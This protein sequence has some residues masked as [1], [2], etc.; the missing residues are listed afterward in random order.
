LG[1]GHDSQWQ[2]HLDE[3]GQS[4]SCA[5]DQLLAG[6]W[7]DMLSHYSKAEFT[8]LSDRLIAISSLVNKIAGLTGGH[9]DSGCWL[10]TIDRC[11][12]WWVESDA[13]SG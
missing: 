6:A 13:S 3:A 5:K 9:Y 12:A 10:E 4:S 2:R 1:F 11:L 8:F 7:F